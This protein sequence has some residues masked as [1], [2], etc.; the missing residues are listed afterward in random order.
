MKKAY[1]LIG[2]LI[3]VVILGIL[4]IGA[5]PS[6]NQIIRRT[7]L[8]EVRN[9]VEAVISGA[10]YYELKHGTITTLP[11]SD[12]DPDPDPPWP[13][14]NVELPNNPV[15][16]YEIL[17]GGTTGKQLRV[18]SG[19]VWLYTYDLPRGPG[20]INGVNPDARYVQELP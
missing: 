14:L 15:C 13:A 5:I 8:K 1:T 7:E 12:P 2:V 6:F 10:R 4:A 17:P 9:V 16:A 18:S 11:I 20:A 19:G 3:V